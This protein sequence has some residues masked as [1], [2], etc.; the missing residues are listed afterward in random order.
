MV[1]GFGRLV[2]LIHPGYAG[3]VDHDSAS[4][5]GIM[6]SAV[7]LNR[8]FPHI[9]QS[10]TDSLLGIYNVYTLVL[11]YMGSPFEMLTQ[12]ITCTRPR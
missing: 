12:L 2:E 5:L 11:A 4:Q 8:N 6:T 10:T 7:S 3:S 1:A 9:D